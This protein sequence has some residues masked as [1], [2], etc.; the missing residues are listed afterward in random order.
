MAVA[1]EYQNRLEQAF[2][3]LPG[4][5]QDALRPAYRPVDDAIHWVCGDP[6][7]L[8]DAGQKYVSIGT[9]VRA[10]SKDVAADARVLEAHWSDEAGRAFRRKMDNIVTAIDGAGE[11]IGETDTILSASARAAVD[12]ANTICD[13]VVSTVEFIISDI[14]VSAALS[15]F[16]FGASAAA[17]LAAAIARWADAAFEV[18]RVVEAI[19][20]ILDMV[21]KLLRELAELFRELKALFELLKSLRKEAGFIAKYTVWTGAKVAVKK[22]VQLLWDAVP[23]VPDQPAG[24]VHWLIEGGKDVHQVVDDVHSADSVDGG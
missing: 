15:L 22:P 8:L 24:G 1:T 18:S 14:A 2:G 6:D 7:A 11:A 10:T 4:F 9:S 23:G 19:V 13:I 12:A 16:T 5:V 21:A 20:K 17:G 3:A